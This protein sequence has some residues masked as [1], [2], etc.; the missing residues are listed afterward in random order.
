MM[1]TEAGELTVVAIHSFHFDGI[2]GCGRGRSAVHTRITEHVDWL[3]EHTE[4]IIRP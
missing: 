4:V 1:I 2:G 3:I